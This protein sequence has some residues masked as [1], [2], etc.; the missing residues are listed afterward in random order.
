[1]ESR[2]IDRFEI[3]LILQAQAGSAEAFDKLVRLHDRRVL[4]LICSIVGNMHDAYDVHQE[5]F[6]NAFRKISSFRFESTLSTW[7]GR[8]AINYSLNWLKRQKR[9]Q[10]LSFGSE[11][12][13]QVS[14]EMEMGYED[15]AEDDLLDEE[16][17]KHI[18]TALQQLPDQQRTVFILKHYQGYKIREIADMMGSAEGTIKNH[19]FRATHRLQKILQP[20]YDVEE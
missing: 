2:K 14:R 7:L 11:N 16:L 12:E 3:E 20:Y 5:T 10:W 13:S 9:R 19:L 8:I 1:M 18:K 6:I 17:S 4:Q 15:A